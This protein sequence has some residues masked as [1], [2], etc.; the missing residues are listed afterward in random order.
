MKVRRK[1]LWRKQNSK[2]VRKFSN[3]RAAKE[4]K[5]LARAFAEP[6]LPDAS[7]VPLPRPAKKL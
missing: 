2:R 7:A 5:R 6:V 1:S 4:R 3:M